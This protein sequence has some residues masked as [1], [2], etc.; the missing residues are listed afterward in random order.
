M[1]FGA[2]IVQDAWLSLITFTNGLHCSFLVVVLKRKWNWRTEK[3][4]SRKSSTFLRTV[5]N[6]LSEMDLRV[7][8]TSWTYYKFISE[9]QRRTAI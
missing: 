8:E 9:V 3:T 1:T 4:V 7:F 6:S 5:T 2:V